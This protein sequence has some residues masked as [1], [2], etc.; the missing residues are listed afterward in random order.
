[1]IF[2]LCQKSLYAAKCNVSKQYFDNYEPAVFNTTN[3]LLSDYKNSPEDCSQKIILMG[4]IIDE[5]CV[6]VP[7]TK[8]YLWQAGCDGKYPY[9]PLRKKIDMH[10]VDIFSA[11]SFLGSGTAIADA[12]GQFHFITIYP[13]SKIK[14]INIRAKSSKIQTL[15]T[16]LQI[17]KLGKMGF[18]P[19]NP[20]SNTYYFDVVVKRKKK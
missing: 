18:C 10:L 12:L 17:N 9:K 1:M 4:R 2:A 3:S 15:Q 16:K 8:V 6:P 7:Y 19:N 13:C 5:Q 20:Q 14:Y 11:N